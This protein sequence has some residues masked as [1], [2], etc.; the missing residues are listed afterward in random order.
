MA[1]CAHGQARCLGERPALG[2]RFLPAY[3][4]LPA[5]QSANVPGQSV[6][7]GGWPDHSS[8]SYTMKLS[9]AIPAVSVLK[10]RFP[11]VTGTTPA[12]LASSISE[13]S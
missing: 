2:G 6:C 11:R 13:G 1:A 9:A 4:P 10:M 7:A 5:R 12:A 8:S 3:V